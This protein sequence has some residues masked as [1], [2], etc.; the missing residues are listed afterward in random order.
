ML[1]VSDFD[2]VMTDQTAEAERVRAIVRDR[3]VAL[4]VVGAAEVE[5]MIAVGE[6]ELERAPAQHGW[7]SAGRITG[8]A[9]EDLFIRHQALCAWWDDR[10][11][12][13]DAGLVALRRALAA[14]PPGSSFPTFVAL[15]DWA[16]GEMGREVKA[17]AHKPLDPEVPRALTTLLD[18]G[19]RLVIVSNS[20]TDRVLDILSASGLG[21]ADHAR[22][23]GARLRVRGDARKFALGDVPR[24]SR[25]GANYDV[26]LSRPHYERIL[27]DERPAVVIGDV[28]SF[29]LAL[30]HDLGRRGVMPPVGLVL[31]RRP[32]SPDW[33]TG[34]F[35]TEGPLA[36][37]R[38]AMLDRFADLPG[39]VDS[40][41]RGP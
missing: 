28:F 8:F 7:R 14:T 31:R 26:D 15:A 20:G 25:F 16:F 12:A 13:G 23:P 30:P 21:A 5:R 4:G 40:L 24:L 19:H 38:V 6:A 17:R 29:D 22:D 11:D 41:V 34:M 39:V 18:A 2:G 10:A 33:V 36:P 27:V 32:Y 37:S 9:S 1:I 35:A 3:L